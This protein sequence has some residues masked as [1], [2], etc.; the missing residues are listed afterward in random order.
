MMRLSRLVP[1]AAIVAAAPAWAASAAEAEHIRLSEEMRKF[2]ARNAWRG[3]ESSYN[4]MLELEKKGVVI[5]GEEHLLGVQAARQLGNVY[6]VYVRLKAADAV[7]PAD[8]LK[9]QIQAIEANYGL[10]KLDVDDKF[11]DAFVLTPERMPMDPGK[12]KAIEVAQKQV[13]EQRKFI[14][15]LPHGRYTLG[16]RTFDVSKEATERT[17]VYLG[18][19]KR[20]KPT[21]DGGGGSVAVRKRQGLRVDLGPQFTSMGSTEVETT[22]LADG[23]P[24]GTPATLASDAA[25]GGRAGAG[26]ELFLSKGWSLMLE[27]GWHGG[28]AG[29]TDANDDPL[30]ASV[31]QPESLGFQSFYGW[32]AP[33]W[34]HDDLAI[35]VG[36]TYSF[37]KVDAAA[38]DTSQGA[39]SGTLTCGG[40]AV[41][42]FY[43]LFDTPGLANSRS[44]FSLAAGVFASRS[45]MTFPWAQLAF[46]IAPEG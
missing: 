14:G 19:A 21:D 8:D 41:S 42:V 18:P 12:R 22:A 3:V 9:G 6:D 13:A 44:G 43:G 32:V 15:M 5:T 31:Q 29:S 26:Y 4:K 1:L 25:L 39:L 28:F 45:M 37:V 36:P 38:E 16:E 30:A 33:T 17:E 7:A 20:K 27:G 46:T 35:T 24:G 2:A 23:G 10:V 34:Y 11:K 40:A